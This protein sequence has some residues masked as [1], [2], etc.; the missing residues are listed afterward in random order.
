MFF[1]HD[2]PSLGKKNLVRCEIKTGYINLA[3]VLKNVSIPV[4]ALS[5]VWICG[6]SL[7]GN[8]G[9]IPTVGMVVC[10]LW[11]LFFVR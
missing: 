1:C 11:V 7:A 2:G 5:K 10:L 8:A 3:E 6:C 4:V 9:S